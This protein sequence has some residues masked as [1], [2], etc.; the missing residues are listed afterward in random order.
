MVQDWEVIELQVVVAVL[1]IYCVVLVEVGCL[2]DRIL[3]AG[4]ILLV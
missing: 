4:Q 1:G 3:V 2:A